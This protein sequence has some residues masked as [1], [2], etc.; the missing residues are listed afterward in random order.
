M[1]PSETSLKVDEI[2]KR[3]KVTTSSPTIN[4][5]IND[6]EPLCMPD[7]HRKSKPA[8]LKRVNK[9]AE[10]LRRQHTR[11]KFRDSLAVKEQ[12]SGKEGRVEDPPHFLTGLKVNWLYV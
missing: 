3:E 11:D 12:T 7:V 4:K 10:C 2:F 6:M 5:P 8:H 1:N 9:G